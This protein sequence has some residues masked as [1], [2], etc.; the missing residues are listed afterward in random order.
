MPTF[1]WVGISLKSYEL[2]VCHLSLLLPSLTSHI[3]RN[4][5]HYP[6]EALLRVICWLHS[7]V[8]QCISPLSVFSVKCS[9]LVKLDHVQ[10]SRFDQDYF[11]GGTLWHIGISTFSGYLMPDGLFMILSATNIPCLYPWAFKMMEYYFIIYSLSFTWHNFI[12]RTLI[13]YVVG[14]WKRKK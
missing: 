1:Q 3:R 5:K 7:K 11:K 9:Y 12:L 10:I 4:Q 6:A 13:K 14:H 2:I 8:A